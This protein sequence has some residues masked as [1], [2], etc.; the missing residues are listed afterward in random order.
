[1]QMSSENPE[2]PATS[3]AN[4]EAKA[5]PPIIT[6]DEDVTS[7]SPTIPPLFKPTKV[8]VLGNNISC[9]PIH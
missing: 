1:M 2:L 7:G 4:N 5:A 9:G 3:A 8:R 6:L